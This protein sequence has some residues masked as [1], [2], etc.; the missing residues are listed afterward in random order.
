MGVT[1]DGLLAGMA[2]GDAQA[3][4][5]F[6]R[7]HQA[8]V[9]GL[10]LTIVGVP[11]VAEEVAQEAFVRAW[12]FA[13]AYDPRRGAVTTWLLAIAR[14][15][16]IDAVRLGRDRPYDP[17]VLIDMISQVNDGQTDDYPEQLADA[18]R[19][20]AALTQLPHDQRVAVVLAAI[21]GLTAREIAEREQIPIGTAK[22]R[23][24]LGLAR[25]RSQ[26][27]VRDE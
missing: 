6:V 11:A 16:A 20:R 13:G 18:H 8:R 24:R 23:I 25:L 15:A 22:T 4:S 9:F 21:Y 3:A 17:D 7:R 10:A 12:R 14:N 1:D 27:E 26:L 19:I 2:A 5:A